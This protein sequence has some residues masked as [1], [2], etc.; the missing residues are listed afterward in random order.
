MVQQFRD[1]LNTEPG[2][3]ATPAPAAPP[4]VAVP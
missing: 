1:I 3:D 4:D 2:K